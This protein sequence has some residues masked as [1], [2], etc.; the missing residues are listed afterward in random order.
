M[1]Q[2]I[3]GN[4]EKLLAGAAAALLVASVAWLAAQK[5]VGGGLSEQP[6]R[7]MLTGAS[8][9]LTA[10]TSPLQPAHRW[11]KPAAQSHGG[12]WLYEVFTPPVIYYNALAKSFTVTPPTVHSEAGIPFGIELL[13]VGFDP[14]RLQ[15]AGYFGGPGDYLAAFVVPGRPETLLARDGRHFEQLGLTLRRFEV[16]KIAVAHNDSWPVY[17][18]AG[19][20]VLHDERTG[21]EVVLDTRAP[22]LSETPRAI[23]RTGGQARSLRE[24]DTFSDDTATYR[25]E[26][27]QV[28]PPEVVVAKQT[29]GLPLPETRILRPSGKD[30][31]LA[32][33]GGVTKPISTKPR[34]GLVT[35]GH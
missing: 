19:V 34:T 23:L 18:V 24:G 32:N 3:K 20:A 35:T 1:I 29:P 25:I 14:Y 5:S 12:G 6:V 27:I 9:P 10:W 11:P 17:D 31:Q 7:A 28:A 16:R 26:R 21:Q 15:L 4:Y 30:A 8:H 33:K 2:L 22:K 13:E